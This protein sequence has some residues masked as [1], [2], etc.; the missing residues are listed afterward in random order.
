MR[1]LQLL[2]NSLLPPPPYPFLIL[3]RTPGYALTQVDKAWD[4][5]SNKSLEI[6]VYLVLVQAGSRFLS[7]PE[8]RYAI[9]ELELLAVSWAIIK[10]NVFLAGLP[11]FAV[12]TDHHPLVPI[13]NSHRLDEIENPRL[14]RLRTKIM[15]Y[16]C[17]AEWIKG[18]VNGMSD[19][20]SRYP[21]ANPTPQEMLAEQDSSNEIAPSVAEIRAVVSSPHESLRLQDLRKHA[22]EDHTYQQLLHYVYEGFPDHRSQLPDECRAYW[23]VRDKLSVDD[24]LVV[25]GCRLVIPSALRKEVLSELHASHQGRLRTKQRAKLIVYWPGLDNE[26]DNLILGC[27]MCQ[28]SLPSN[29][30][31]PIIQKPRPTR[32]FQEIAVDFCSYAGR[33]FLVLVDTCT[34]WPD[35]VFMGSN[36]T[37]VTGKLKPL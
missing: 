11:H 23:K 6:L 10:C 29:P 27:T 15:G 20:L 17:T 13:L 24:G 22:Q 31:E 14:Q 3:Q 34:D 1:P 2:G 7:D 35:V 21:I 37:R 9:I 28:D 5:C 33:D 32:P 30:P 25:Y 18:S 26:I 19:A 16:N 12:L 4:S 8:S 36:T